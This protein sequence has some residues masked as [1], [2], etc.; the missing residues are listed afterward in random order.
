M[1]ESSGLAD[2]ECAERAAGAYPQGQDPVGQ[3]TMVR[4]IPPTPAEIVGITADVHEDSLANAPRPEMYLPCA[5]L[6]APP[7]ASLSV[8]TEGDPR[9]FASAVRA[10]VRSL[11]RD[12]A[13]AQ[14]RTLEEV[15]EASVGRLRLTS[16]LVGVFAGSAL[17]L[18]VV[19]LY[20]VTAY[21]VVQRT[22]EI[23][24]RR[25]LGAQPA[26]ILR[27]VMGEAFIVTLAGLA[28]GITVALALTGL[29]KDLLFQV[30]ALDPIAFTGATLLFLLV[31]LAAGC[32][33][34]R[35]AIKIDPMVALR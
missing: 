13:V 6:R 22:Q 18:A 33:P 8:R 10:A 35:R 3:H 24:I 28:L 19:G 17:L 1:G 30:N 2:K 7:S 34:A 26:D 29:V 12:Q 32:I 31:A 14:V 4:N 15:L 21:S 5:Q 11:N 16:E 23:C 20:G 25:A 27:S 9:R